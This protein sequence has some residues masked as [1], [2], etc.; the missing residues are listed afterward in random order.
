MSHRCA[1]TVLFLSLGI[2]AY[3]CSSQEIESAA[4]GATR[5]PGVSSAPAAPAPGVAE[6]LAASVQSAGPTLSPQDLPTPVPLTADDW[7][8]FRGARRDGIADARGLLRSWPAEGPEVLWQVAVG[9][10]Y[11]APVAVDGKV[12]FNDYD[13]SAGQWMVRCLSLE[14][15]DELWR[16]SV[17]KRIRP[18][19]GITRTMPATDGGFVVA[20]DP[21]CEIH[22]LDA[23]NGAKIWSLALPQTFDAQIPPWYN[24]QC[25]LLENDRVIVATGGKALLVALDKATGKVLWQTPNEADAAM[26]H[27]SIMP[28]TI[29]GVKQYLYTTLDALVGVADDDGRLLWRFPWKFNVAVPTSP[30]CLD[31]GRVLLTSCYQAPTGMCQVKREGEQWVATELYQLPPTGWNSEVHTPIVHRGYLF[32]VGKKRR[33]LWTCLNLDGS[34]RWTSD[35]KASFGLG[36]Y[37]LADGM[38]FVLDGNTGQLRLIDAQADQYVELASAKVLEG[39]DAWAPPVISRGRLLVR[40]LKQLV[41]LNVAGPAAPAETA[42]QSAAATP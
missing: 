2:A 3:G 23:R 27:S 17:A 35:R 39:P 13:E 11:A 36:G 19:H 32:G 24:G 28:A 22:C 33:G 41:C 12:Y 20:I 5:A 30:V 25:P 37:V 16:Y 9:Q 29:D 15:G 8:Q 1:V 42:S 4:T 34:E 6:S 21:K 26:S 14:T 40:D 10:G 7:P 18:N 38:F 31:D